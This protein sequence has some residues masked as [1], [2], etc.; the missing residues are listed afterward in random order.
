MKIATVYTPSFAITVN[1]PHFLIHLHCS[2]TVMCMYYSVH[3]GKMAAIT[4]AIL[5]LPK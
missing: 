1:R 4:Y 3:A 5:I 2:L